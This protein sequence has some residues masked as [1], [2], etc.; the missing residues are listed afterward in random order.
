MLITYQ[1]HIGS[2]HVLIRAAGED[3]PVLG[4]A[5]GLVGQQIRHYRLG[6]AVDTTDPLAIA[7]HLDVFLREGMGEAL[8]VEAARDFAAENT[9]ER[10]AATLFEAL[11]DRDQNSSFF[12][13]NCE[14]GACDARIFQYAI[15]RYHRGVPCRIRKSS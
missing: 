6:M 11:G 2:S 12:V 3:T 4:S 13:E 5:P 8:D 10:F 7:S 15:F 14:D 9:A 1:R